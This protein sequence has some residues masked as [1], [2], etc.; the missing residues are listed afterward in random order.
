MAKKTP[1]AP[2]K[3]NE[4]LL[5]LWWLEVTPHYTLDLDDELSRRLYEERMA[6]YYCDFVDQEAAKGLMFDI[7]GNLIAVEEAP[8][9]MG[10]GWK[11]NWA[12]R[13]AKKDGGDNSAP[14]EREKPKL[15]GGRNFK[16]GSPGWDPKH[17]GIDPNDPDWD[18]YKSGEMLP[19]QFIQAMENFAKAT[20]HFKESYKE[21]GMDVAY[22]LNSTA[23]GSLGEKAENKPV[24]MIKKLRATS[25]GQNIRSGVY[26]DSP[27]KHLRPKVT[28][29]NA[30]EQPPP[31]P[32]Y[33]SPSSNK[34]TA[35][36]LSPPPKTMPAPPLLQDDE[37]PSPTKAATTTKTFSH[38]DYYYNSTTPSAGTLGSS[39]NDKNKT[40]TTNAESQAP[41]V[42]KPSASVAKKQPQTAD[43]TETEEGDE[44]DVFRAPPKNNTQ[45]QEE[46][47]EPEGELEDEVQ[48]EEEAPEGEDEEEEYYED[49]QVEADDQGVEGGDDQG[50]EE[51]EFDEE[52]YI[53]E[54]PEEGL[55][56]LQATV[57]AKM[58]ELKRLQ[59]Q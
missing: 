51:E 36:K 20:G 23:Y 16:P 45:N 48:E 3:R 37:P 52:T 14:V 30:K 43:E 26:D 15:F 47:Q 10:S 9:N 32:P 35:A 5:P 24:W 13:K 34:K 8:A 38:K 12:G 57:A 56:N 29:P 33:S 31:P 39:Q 11:S 54:E 2:P 46:D 53:E 7:D 58:A 1:Q 17:W 6:M 21:M 42:V 59:A 19:P 50:E 44:V 49:E 40:T 41:A 25:A 55:D 18:K 28:I 27:N 22:N 4:A